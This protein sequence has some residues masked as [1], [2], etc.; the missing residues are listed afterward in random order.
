[1]DLRWFDVELSPKDRLHFWLAAG[2]SA[3]GTGEKRNAAGTYDPVEFEAGSGAI[4]GLRWGHDLGGGH[5]DVAFMY[6]TGLLEDFSMGRS[7]AYT[8]PALDVNGRR[9][10]R[11]VESL[12]WELTPKLGIQTAFIYEDGRSGSNVDSRWLSVAARPVYYLTDHYH[13]AFEAGFSSVLDESE[14][15]GPGGGKAGERTLWRLTIAPEVAFGKG[16]F[17][18][19]LVRAYLTHT[20]WNDANANLQN[21]SSLLGDFNTNNFTALNGTRSETQAGVQC[22]VWF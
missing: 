3:P 11:F 6:G 15:N 8:N 10:W 1:L 22:E 19:P 9:R 12:F 16:Y 17:D 5:N 13:L 20:E 7:I 2:Y 4:A 21:T 18:R 14:T